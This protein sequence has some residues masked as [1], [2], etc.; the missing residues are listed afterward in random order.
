MKAPPGKQFHRNY[1]RIRFGWKPFTDWNALI[2][3]K[4]INGA[5]DCL[6]DPRSIPYFYIL[7]P[8]SSVAC[9]Y[10]GDCNGPGRRRCI[11]QM[12]RR[13]GKTSNG[14][15]QNRINHVRSPSLRKYTLGWRTLTLQLSESHLSDCD[16]CLQ[17]N[18]AKRRCAK[19]RTGR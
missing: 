19:Q 15:P 18:I 4:Y 5:W 13:N 14:I 16:N 12:K 3:N 11:E 8:G 6:T 1:I 17:R 9:K 10:A 2:K 7:I